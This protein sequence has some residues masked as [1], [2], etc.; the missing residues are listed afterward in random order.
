MTRNNLPEDVREAALELRNDD[1]SRF[2]GSESPR[3]VAFAVL[4]DEI[5]ELQE[6]RE[7]AQERQE[8]LRERIG[9]SSSDD[10]TDGSQDDVSRKQAELRE[11]M[12]R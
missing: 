12:N 10:G 6:A 2:T 4:E 3:N 9:V 8:E 1:N 5:A 11:R 7:E